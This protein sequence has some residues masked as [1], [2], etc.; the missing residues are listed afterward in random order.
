MSELLAAYPVVI[1]LPVLWGDMDAYRHVNN[2]VY[3]RYFECARIAYFERINLYDLRDATGVGPI[4]GSVQCRFR[5]PL[6][7]PDTISVGA[8]VTE[9]KDDR[10]EVEHCVVSHRHQKLAAQRS[11]VV[12]AYDYKAQKKAVWPVEVNSRIWQLQ[13]QDK[14]NG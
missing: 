8:R 11:G 12:M 9:T 14:A 3:F 1:Q 4:L 10:F 13:E 2:T 7:Y 5:L 6:T